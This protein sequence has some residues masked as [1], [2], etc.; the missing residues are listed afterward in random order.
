MYFLG[1]PYNDKTFAKS[2]TILWTNMRNLYTKQ[3]Y[4]LWL[5]GIQKVINSKVIL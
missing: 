1:I 2:S 4:I 5:V 3:N